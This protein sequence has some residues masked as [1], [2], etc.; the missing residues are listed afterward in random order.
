MLFCAQIDVD[1]LSKKL[2]AIIPLNFTYYFSSTSLMRCIYSVNSVDFDLES[3]SK[4]DEDQSDS[5]PVGSVDGIVT[6][7]SQT[8][9]D[10]TDSYPVGSIDGI[11]ASISHT[12]EVFTGDPNEICYGVT[13]RKLRFIFYFGCRLLFTHN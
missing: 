8:D 5:C 10:Q 3:L 6:F 7:L 4:I 2:Y 9:E 12:A 13:L 11:D 1:P